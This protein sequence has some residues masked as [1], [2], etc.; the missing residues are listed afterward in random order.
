MRTGIFWVTVS[1]LLATQASATIIISC[2]E[3]KD[4]P[5]C[6]HATCNSATGQWS[7]CTAVT[8]GTICDDGNS[9]TL[10]ETCQG[11]A[12]SAG[13]SCNGASAATCTGG[14]RCHSNP[15]V[16]DANLQS[17]TYTQVCTASL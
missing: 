10:H 6:Q 4:C 12:C 2:G 9:F 5:P 15:G 7:A 17:C 16:C 3:P 1:A 11:G 14:D 13:V 8:N